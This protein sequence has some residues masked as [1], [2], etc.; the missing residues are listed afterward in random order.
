MAWLPATQTV[1]SGAKGYWVFQANLGTNTL[2]KNAAGSASLNLGSS[3]PAGSLI[4][5][6]P[7]S[8]MGKSTATANS[9]ALFETKSS[10]PRRAVSRSPAS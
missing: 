4:V 2:A 9:A 5:A 6:F 7:S 3:L 8:G 10:G 1:D